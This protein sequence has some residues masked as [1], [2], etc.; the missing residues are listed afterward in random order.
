MQKCPPQCSDGKGADKTVRIARQTK[1][2]TAFRRESIH[3]VHVVFFLLAYLLNLA[4]H[5]E[6][7]SDV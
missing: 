1:S 6:L 3:P 5:P 4:S 7:C 2:Q